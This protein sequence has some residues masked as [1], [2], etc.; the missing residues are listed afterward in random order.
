MTFWGHSSK[1]ILCE[2]MGF[3][4]RYLGLFWTELQRSCNGG[5][6]YVELIANGE[7][8]WIIRGVSKMAVGIFMDR[9][10]L[11]IVSCKLEMMKY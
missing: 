5:G 10:K 6:A 7:R 4:V 11:F 1:K 2:N 8:K 3:F 9:V